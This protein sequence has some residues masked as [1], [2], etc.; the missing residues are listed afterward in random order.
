MRVALDRLAVDVEHAVDHLNAVA[1]QSDDPLDVV[2]G[3]VLRQPEH[4]H[5]AATDRLA[6]NAAGENRRRKWQRVMGVAVGIFRDEQI[7]AD[8]QRRNHRAGRDIERLK[9]E[10][11]DDERDNQRMDDHAYGLG[12]STLLPLGPGLHAHRPMVPLLVR[13]PRTCN[14]GT[15]ARNCTRDFAA[16]RS[17]TL[18]M[19]YAYR[20]SFADMTNLSSLPCV[21]WNGIFS[22]VSAPRLRVQGWRSPR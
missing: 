17:F 3:V 14:L 7:I 16:G 19:P 12:E 18:V 11:A 22:L 8:E 21:R 9:Q 15:P 13:A 1:R 4:H 5:V 6:D 2:G 20:Q 10:G